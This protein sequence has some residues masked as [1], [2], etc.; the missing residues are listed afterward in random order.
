M[1]TDPVAQ[2]ALRAALLMLCAVLAACADV[3]PDPIASPQLE[4]G[5]TSSNGGG[6]RTLGNQPNVGLTTRVAPY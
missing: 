2:S 4:S 6:A 3:R 5:V 1:F